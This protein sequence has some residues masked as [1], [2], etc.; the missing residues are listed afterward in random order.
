MGAQYAVTRFFE[1]S[2]LGP[3]L[4]P[5]DRRDRGVGRESGPT[6]DMV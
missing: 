4:P 2:E 1:I 5:G 6:V 3:V